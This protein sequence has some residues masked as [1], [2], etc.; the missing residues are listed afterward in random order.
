VSNISNDNVGNE[1]ISG[2]GTE[3]FHGSTIPDKCCNP[4]SRAPNPQFPECLDLGALQCCSAQPTRILFN[5]QLNRAECMWPQTALSALS[6][7]HYRESTFRS[8]APRVHHGSRARERTIPL[9]QHAVLTELIRSLAHGCGCHALH[10]RAK[11]R[12]KRFAFM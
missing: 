7:R 2:R 1:A 10:N 4:V 11:R 6:S 8:K 5:H 12:M 9:S 3:S